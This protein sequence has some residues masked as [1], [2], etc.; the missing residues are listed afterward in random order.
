M[1]QDRPRHLHSLDIARGIAAFAVVF[2]HWHHFFIVRLHLAADFRPELQPMYRLFRLFY[3]HG[4]E[5]V[6]LFFSLSGFIFFW[7]FAERIA[8]GKL[9]LRQ[10]FV[11]RLSRLY[12]LHLATLLIVAVMQPLFRAVNGSYFVFGWNDLTHFVLN[13]L[14]LSSIG[15]GNG[16][17][18]NGP[19]WSVSVEMTLYAIFFLYCAMTKPRLLSMTAVSLFAY[20]ILGRYKPG[21]G[22]AVGAFFVGGCM[23]ELYSALTRDGARTRLARSIAFGVLALSV[24]LFI[25]PAAVLDAL[26]YLVTPGNEP[27]FLTVVLFP[28]GILALAL[29]EFV[30]PAIF[31]RVARITRLGELSYAVYLIHFPLQLV[32]MLAFTRLGINTRVFYSPFAL[33]AF[34]VTLIALGLLSHYQFE[35]PIQRWLRSRYDAER[36]T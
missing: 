19:S 32:L 1:T 29:A 13:L 2:W 34:F 16:M 15:R 30:T 22:A 3:L 35:M 24:A 14:L 9:S 20:L 31:A 4:Q 36:A 7:L 8:S 11:H 21:L 5:A 28:C 33:V 18:F 23:A 27:D 25:A 10:F 6:S 12:P 26:P 17:S